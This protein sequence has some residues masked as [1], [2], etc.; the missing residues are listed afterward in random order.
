MFLLRWWLLARLH[1]QN[2]WSKVETSLV[3]VCGTLVNGDLYYVSL[4]IQNGVN[5]CVGACFC[6][7]IQIL[8]CGVV[9]RD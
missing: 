3:C 6:L 1:T 2:E 7:P 8:K 5:K 9:T 4:F